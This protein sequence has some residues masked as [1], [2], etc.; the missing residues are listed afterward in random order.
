M[1]DGVADLAFGRAG[2]TVAGV[3]RGVDGRFES[4]SGHWDSSD[5]VLERFLWGFFGI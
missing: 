2:D 1:I 3:E 4:S 5:R